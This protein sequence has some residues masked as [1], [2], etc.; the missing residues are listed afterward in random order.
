MP[1]ISVVIPAYNAAKT[2]LETIRSVQR[3]SFTDF[4]LI[5]IDD[6]STDETL[7]LLATVEDSRLRILS[8]ENG[9]ISMARNRGIEHARGEF[10]SFLDADDLWTA[11]K[12]E[13]QL[14]VLRQQPEA[15]AAYSWTYIIDEHSKWLFTIDPVYF[16]GNVY[17]QMLVRNF[18]VS[19]SSNVL[20][21]RLAVESTGNFDIS[22]KYAQDKD[23][24]IRLAAKWPF[25]LVPHYQILYR[26]HGGTTSSRIDL[27]E[28]EG[29][30]VIERAFQ[31]AP[32][33][34]QPLKQQALAN[35]Y[36][37]T[38][39]LC[40]TYAS[41]AAAARQAGKRLRKATRLYP[42]ILL[43]GRAQR[44]AGKSLL[45]RAFPQRVANQLLRLHSKVHNLSHRGIAI[46]DPVI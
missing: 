46:I 33:E 36:L 43:N 35:T 8:F 1:A 23:Y 7:S 6:G 15:G 2:I 40:L 14:A 21:R 28:K 41:D 39:E 24:W 45:L 10:I 29:I 38:A 20:I 12:L 44:L 27:A 19:G 18:L 11:D 5:V 16:E 13:R 31:V 22:L 26:R 37:H 32:P 34:L 9:G 42:K 4:E 3:Q 17:A 25:A 30:L